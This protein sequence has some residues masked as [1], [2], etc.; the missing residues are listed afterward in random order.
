MLSHGSIVA[1]IICFFVCSNALLTFHIAWNL[2]LHWRNARP[3][4]DYS[5]YIQWQISSSEIVWRR[6]FYWLR[7]SYKQDSVCTYQATMRRFRLLSSC[8]LFRSSQHLIYWGFTL[9]CVILL[10]CVYC[11]KLLLLPRYV[12]TALLGSFYLRSSL[13][14]D[15]TQCRFVVH[16]RSFGI[17]Y[18]SYLWGSSNTLTLEDGMDMLSRNVGN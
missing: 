3:G 11:R 5:L 1:L 6:K 12:V 9:C 8:I 7:A 15:V 17:I 10:L 16:C 13:F 18:L 14:C 2:I 4:S